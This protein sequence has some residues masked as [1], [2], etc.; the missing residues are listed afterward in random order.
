[1]NTENIIKPHGSPKGMT[2]KDI[3]GGVPEEIGK[4]SEASLKEKN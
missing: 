2:M 4:K 3:W 1:M